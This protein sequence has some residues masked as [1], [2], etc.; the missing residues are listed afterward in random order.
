MKQIIWF[1]LIVLFVA[2]NCKSD[3][4][5]TDRV[6]KG[7]NYELNI[8]DEQKA[9]LILFPCFPCDIE[10]TKTEAE[11]LKN[12]EKEGI[13]TLLLNI[14]KKLYLTEAEKI[15]YAQLLNSI[16]DTNKIVKENVFIGGFSSGGNISVVLSNF[17]IKTRHAI[18]PK[19]IFVVDSPLDL[20]ALYNNA[21]NDLNK[22]ANAVAV[23]E[24]KFLID[25]FEN[26][27]G[28]PN[29]NIEKYKTISPYLISCNSMYNIEYLK[30]I[31]IRFYC[32]PALEWQMENKNRKYEE[33]NA[34]QLEKTYLALVQVG[35]KKAELIKTKN[36]GIRANGEK[37]PHS[38]SIVEKENLVR[39]ILE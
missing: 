26:S 19:G 34:H 38:W 36:R 17:L 5:T 4:N 24:G 16:F 9:V 8:A 2:A 3:S 33:L 11:F 1:V 31:K 22:N 10:N 18:Q 35:S 21:K 30:D 13:T 28:K 6:I 39:W 25:L 15:E 14:N 23:E 7:E 32:E 29:K 20:E 37:N 27:I 12:I